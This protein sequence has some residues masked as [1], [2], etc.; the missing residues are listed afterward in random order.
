VPNVWPDEGF[1]WMNFFL[2][3]IFL[4]APCGF[5]MLDSVS[6][7]SVGESSYVFLLARAI[8]FSILREP[9]QTLESI[10]PPNNFFSF[11]YHLKQTFGAFLVHVIR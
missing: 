11:S 4:Y 10:S 2:P 3:K 1:F 7:S 5:L 6:N 9:P 8:S